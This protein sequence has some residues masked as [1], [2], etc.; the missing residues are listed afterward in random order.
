MLDLVGNFEDRFSLVAAQLLMCM[1]KPWDSTALIVADLADGGQ[2][3]VKG[4]EKQVK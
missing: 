3:I 2:A 1:F 4:S